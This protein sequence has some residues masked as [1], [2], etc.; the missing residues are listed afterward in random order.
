MNTFGKLFRIT[1]FGESHGS[2]IGCVIDGMP[3][4]IFID[5][6]FIQEELN[7]R[8]GGQNTYATQRKEEDRIQI[9]SGVFE[10]YSTG[11]PIGIFIENNN[12]KSKDYD[13][14]KDLFRPGHGDF[15]YFHKYGIRDYRGGGRSSARESVARVAS[16]A[17]A[18][19]ILREFNIETKSGILQIGE[20]QAQ[21]IDFANARKSEIFSLDKDVENLQKEIIINTKK[22]HDSIGGVALISAFNI[23]IGL[24]E[25]LY[26]KL[27]SAIGELMLGLNGVKAVEIGDG[28]NS[29]KSLGSSNNDQIRKSGF[30]SNHSGGILGGISN[31]EQINIKV[32]FKPTPSIFKPQKTIDENKNEV[33]LMLKGRHDPCIAIRGSV[34]AESLLA[35]ILADMLLLNMVSKI[36]HLKKIYK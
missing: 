16:G 24:G 2:G 4:G 32:Y 18:K 26:Y 1:T 27:D 35:I 33:D 22:S 9:L 15:T 20:I 8:K 21:K 28:I 30:T 19:L 3:A 13:G 31:G 5:L 11:M 25:P 10:G 17:F 34:V 6:E 14:I 7:R 23:P 36:E 29:A 12:T